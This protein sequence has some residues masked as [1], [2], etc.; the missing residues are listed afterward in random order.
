MSKKEIS[1]ELVR[2]FHIFW[3]NFPFPVM[4]THRDRTILDINRAA[5]TAGYTAG[6]RCIDLGAR[7]ITAGAWLIRLFRNRPQ[8]G[9]WRI[10]RLLGSSLTVTGFRWP[11]RRTSSCTSSPISPHM[12]QS[13][14][15][16]KKS[17]EKPRDAAPVAAPEVTA[18]P[19]SGKTGD[20]QKG[21]RYGRLYRFR[22][23]GALAPGDRRSAGNY[24]RR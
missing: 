11:V 22:S 3:D 23:P 21:G 12:P 16:R 5:A 6:T 15:S 13:I 18:A 7:K 19:A 14:C 20:I 1:E 17:A 8:N 9:L 10:R 24:F 4:L 2:N